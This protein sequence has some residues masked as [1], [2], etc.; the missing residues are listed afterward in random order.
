MQRIKQRERERER[1]REKNTKKLYKFLPQTR[2]SH[3]PLA[4][5]RRVHYNV[6]S[7]YKCSLLKLAR[8]FKCSSTTA[9]DFL[10]FWTQSRDFY[11]QAQL[12]ETS[13]FKQNYKEKCLKLNTWYTISGAHNTNQ[14]QTLNTFRIS[15]LWTLIRNSKWTFDA[16]QFWQCFGAFKL[17]LRL[18]QF[19]KSS[20]L[21]IEV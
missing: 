6:I 8:D 20:L 4:L 12:Q 3:V 9:R 18:L 11:A 15:K 2:S 7:D 14:I 17:L 16:E 13:K 21:Y 1:E 10:S 5:P 19:S